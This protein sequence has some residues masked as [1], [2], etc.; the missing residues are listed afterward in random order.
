MVLPMVR[1]VVMPRGAARMRRPTKLLH[2]LPGCTR[3]VG[4]RTC[5]RRGGTSQL[6]PSP[7]PAARGC[8]RSRTQTCTDQPKAASEPL[9][10]VAP[11]L[12]RGQDNHSP[13]NSWVINH[14]GRCPGAQTK[15]VGCRWSTPAAGGRHATMSRPKTLA[16]GIQNPPAERQQPQAACATSNNAKR[17]VLTIS[18]THCGLTG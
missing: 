2:W 12:K 17:L 9:Q 6:F 15:P 8:C 18:S 14:V 4:V 5:E 10:F 3:Q 1:S 16:K 13:E 11:G 7:C